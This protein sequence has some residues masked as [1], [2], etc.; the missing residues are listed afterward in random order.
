MRINIIKFREEMSKTNTV[1][2]YSPHCYLLRNLWYPIWQAPRRDISCE[3]HR[4][5]NSVNYVWLQCQLLISLRQRDISSSGTA[6]ETSWREY[7]S[8]GTQKVKIFIGFFFLNFNL[9]SQMCSGICLRSSMSS[10]QTIQ[11]LLDLSFLKQKYLININI[12]IQ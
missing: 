8:G 10:S 4:E 9:L 7:S 6:D 12:S 5:K 1:Y 3:W 11:Y 2:L